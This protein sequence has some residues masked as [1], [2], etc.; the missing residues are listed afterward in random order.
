MLKIIKKRFSF[1]L[2]PQKG[3]KELKN[4]SF[5][6]SVSEYLKL[7]G[8]LVLVVGAYNFIFNI[9]KAIYFDLFL[10]LE[11]KY[12]FMLNYALGKTTSLMFFYLFAGTFVLFFISM[13]LKPFFRKIKYIYLLQILLFS[14]TPLLFFGWISIFVHSLLIWSLFLFYVGIK[15]VDKSKVSKNSINQRD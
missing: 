15:S 13:L 5:E 2:N 1:L 12:W 9:L 11:I 8:L 3:F 6:S 7:L 4:S 10:D 14:L